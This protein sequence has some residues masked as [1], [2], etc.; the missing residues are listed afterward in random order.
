MSRLNLFLLSSHTQLAL[1]LV[2]FFLL[3]F[4]IVTHWNYVFV[5][6]KG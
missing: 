6:T 3:A 1:F 4:N 2:G 5:F